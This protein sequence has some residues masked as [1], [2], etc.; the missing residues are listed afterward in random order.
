MI[1]MQPHWGTKT[2]ST[3]GHVFLYPHVRVVEVIPT[4]DY[5]SASATLSE[6]KNV[7]YRIETGAG[8]DSI[9]FELSIY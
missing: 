8:F 7:P 3:V 1:L 9:N 6:F 5:T 2:A 4:T